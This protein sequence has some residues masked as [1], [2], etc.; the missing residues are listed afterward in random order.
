[1]R[2]VLLD[3]NRNIATL[4]G[5]LGEM[6][7]MFYDKQMKKMMEKLITRGS[8]LFFDVVHAIER[9]KWDR[10]AELLLAFLDEA[11]A[12]MD[13]LTWRIALK[14]FEKISHTVRE[15]LQ[16]VRAQ[17]IFL[18]QYRQSNMAF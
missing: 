3:L 18:D 1:M 14:P 4:Q 9:M 8:T 17:V 16:V 11:D 2:K 7:Y 13:D 6:L 10:V 12:V 15:L 5:K